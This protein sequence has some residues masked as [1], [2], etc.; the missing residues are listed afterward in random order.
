MQ[1]RDPAEASAIVR[2]IDNPDCG[3][4]GASCVR[5]TGTVSQIQ[6]NTA[7]WGSM[8]WLRVITHEF[9]HAMF[10]AVDTYAG[11]TAG[12]DA[13][14]TSSVMGDAYEAASGFVYVWPD[15]D[16]IASAK[17]WLQGKAT[18]IVQR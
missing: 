7:T 9:G 15:E 1:T 6:I 17:L 2:V 14:T 4:V 10:A 8:R 16:D 13:S 11:N 5:T 18:Q 3:K 12:I